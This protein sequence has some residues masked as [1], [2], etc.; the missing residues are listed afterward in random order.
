MRWF[1]CSSLQLLLIP[2]N[3]RWS[4]TLGDTLTCL[5]TELL[6]LTS[7]LLFA[8]Q[9]FMAVSGDGYTWTVLPLKGTLLLHFVDLFT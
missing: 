2:Q 6:D 7:C 9:T 1:S 8:G 4:R 5:V 3:E